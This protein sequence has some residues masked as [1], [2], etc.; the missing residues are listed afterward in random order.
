MLRRLI[1]TVTLVAVLAPAA[2]AQEPAAKDRTLDAA[3]KE[4]VIDGVLKRIDEAYVFPDVAR[5][6]AEAIRSRQ[7]KKEYDAITSGR[8]FA[9]VLTDH[10]R[11]VCKDKHLGVR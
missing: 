6:M 8:E 7:E 1:V 10:L 9:R 11:E 4:A 5:K 3:E 2:F